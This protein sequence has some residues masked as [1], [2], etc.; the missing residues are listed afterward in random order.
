MTHAITNL[1]LPQRLFS[2]D[3]E[4]F[5]FIFLFLV[6]HLHTRLHPWTETLELN[7]WREICMSQRRLINR[8]TFCSVKFEFLNFFYFTFLSKSEFLFILS[9]LEKRWIENRWMDVWKKT[10][11]FF[12][13]LK[14]EFYSIFVHLKFLSSSLL[15]SFHLEREIKEKQKITNTIR[16]KKK[17]ESIIKRIDNNYIFSTNW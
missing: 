8:L 1:N 2:S 15:V 14:L 10:C 16:K 11:L 6:T 13:S 9:L 17:K 3:A 4:S 5:V 12:H 7:K